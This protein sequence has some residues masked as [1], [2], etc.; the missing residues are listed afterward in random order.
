MSDTEE[1]FFDS[2]WGYTGFHETYRTKKEPTEEEVKKAEQERKLSEELAEK[3]ESDKRRKG[4]QE[5]EN[6]LLISVT[7]NPQPKMTYYDL[8]LLYPKE[9]KKLLEQSKDVDHGNGD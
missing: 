3:L 7:K 6:K 5:Y 8:A 4:R 9:Y 1:E 2:E